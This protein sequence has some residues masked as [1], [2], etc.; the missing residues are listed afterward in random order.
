MDRSGQQSRKRGADPVVFPE[1]PV[2][3]PLMDQVDFVM[4]APIHLAHLHPLTGQH[5]IDMVPGTRIVA[6]NGM[7]S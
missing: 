7:S 3:G 1:D 4:H 6:G 2:R 5:T